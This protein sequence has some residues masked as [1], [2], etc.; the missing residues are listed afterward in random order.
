MEDDEIEL[1]FDFDLDLDD[2]EAVKVR[3]KGIKSS[4]EIGKEEKCKRII[5]IQL[6]MLEKSPDNYRAL[7]DLIFTY[8]IMGDADKVK[9]YLGKI[10]WLESDYQVATIKLILISHKYGEETYKNI[11]LEKMRRYNNNRY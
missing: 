6:R 5:S 4:N 11:L 1:A 9:E 7:I 3:L 10:V 2:I 8:D